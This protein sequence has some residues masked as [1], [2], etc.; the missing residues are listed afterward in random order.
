MQRCFSPVR[1]CNT[2]RSPVL[3]TKTVRKSLQVRVSFRPIPAHTSGLERSSGVAEQRRM[4]AP[5]AW[6][7]SPREKFRD[8]TMNFSASGSVASNGA[9]FR[10]GRT[11]SGDR[12]AREEVAGRTSGTT[13]VV[14]PRAALQTVTESS[15]DDVFWPCRARRGLW[16]RTKLALAARMMPFSSK[17]SA[18]GSSSA[19]SSCCSSAVTTNS[20]MSAGELALKRGDLFFDRS[21][22]GTHLQ[23]GAREEA[24]AGECAPHEVVEEGV[25]Y[26]D[27]LSESGAACECG[28]DDLGLEDPSRFV[29]GGELEILFR[30]EVGVDAA[31]AHVERAGEVAD[32]EPFEAVERRERHGLAHDRFASA[33]SVGALLPLTRHVDKIA[34]SVVLYVLQHDRSCYLGGTMTAHLQQRRDGDVRLQDPEATSV[35]GARVRPPGFCVHVDEVSRRVRVH[36]RG[37]ITLLDAVSFTVA[38]GELVAIVGPSGAGKTTLLE[39]IAGIAPA[40]AGSVRFDGIDLHANLRKFRGV[41]GYVPQD[42]IIHADLPLEHTLRYAAR[43][44]LP[45]STTA[46]EVD[47]AVRA[48]I[49]TVGLTEHADRPGRLPERRAAQARQRR[50]RAAHRTARL[51]PGRADVR[52]RPGDERGADRPPA[53]A[54]R[55][56]GDCRV[57]HALGRGPRSVRSRRVH[58]AGRTSRLRRHR[59]RSARALRGRL[60]PGALPPP[61][62]GGR[63]SPTP[64]AT[65]GR[66]VGARRR[67]P[68]L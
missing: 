45:S 55:P 13:M 58:G 4:I 41:I 27:E 66:G 14:L 52:P 31:L 9:I 46:A 12:S 40:S 51:L 17:V 47:D 54:R 61:G 8:P 67:P 50:R 15:A 44:R 64:P 63:P 24:A 28:F 5:F 26:C 21:G 22:P 19:G 56:V 49:D 30:A 34:R 62:R 23:D 65:T 11:A 2:G 59:R 6:Q 33:F 18:S 7:H 1:K 48:A 36:G 53:R 60:G 29:H 39:T 38:A 25:A 42:D 10:R 43:L 68:R 16:C 3:C 35:L 20:R 32:R 37:E 57:H